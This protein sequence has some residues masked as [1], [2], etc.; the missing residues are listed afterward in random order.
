[1]MERVGGG[2]AIHREQRW[3]KCLHSTFRYIMQ[4][5][6]MVPVWFP[7]FYV[8]F[9]EQSAEYFYSFCF[10]CERFMACV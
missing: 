7:S 8:A 1:M 5:S 9:R 3:R 2:E 4:G 6:E 10:L